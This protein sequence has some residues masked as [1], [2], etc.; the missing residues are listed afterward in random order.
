ML[1]RIWTGTVYW[2]VCYVPAVK[3][4]RLNRFRKWP[5]PNRALSELPSAG[6]TKLDGTHADF[7]RLGSAMRD[8]D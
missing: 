8:V 7:L 1:R 3:L 5:K 2:G 6:L 4:R